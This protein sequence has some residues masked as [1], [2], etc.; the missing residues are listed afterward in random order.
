[1]YILS[2]VFKKAQVLVHYAQCGVDQISTGK[3][4]ASLDTRIAEQHWIGHDK[5][6]TLIAWGTANHQKEVQARQYF[7]PLEKHNF[8][9][10]V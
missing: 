1:M 10:S 2:P 6:M 3:N 8:A 7:I 9:E 5:P 4:S